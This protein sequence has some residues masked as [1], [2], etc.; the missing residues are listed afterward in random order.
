[1]KRPVKIEV[2]RKDKPPQSSKYLTRLRAS[3]ATREAERAKRSQE[4]EIVNGRH[5]LSLLLATTTLVAAGLGFG[6][7]AAAPGLVRCDIAAT[8]TL[9]QAENLLAVDGGG[10]NLSGNFV[11]TGSVTGFAVNSSGAFR[12]CGHRGT[13]HTVQC[14]SPVDQPDAEPWADAFPAQAPIISHVQSDLITIP[15]NTGIICTH[16][17]NGHTLLTHAHLELTNFVCKQGTTT[18]FSAPNGQARAEAASQIIVNPLLTCPAG[19]APVPACFN[20][21]TFVGELIAYST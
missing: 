12:F 5:R 11:C 9:S 1:V 13:T 15:L 7:A 2:L 8:V 3:D 17:I 21:L 10:G 16:G 20:T 19:P 14:V 4:V 18:V 6:P